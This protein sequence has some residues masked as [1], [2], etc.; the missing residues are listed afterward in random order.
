MNDPSTRLQFAKSLQAVQDHDDT[1]KKYT[2]AVPQVVP[3]AIPQATTTNTSKHTTMKHTHEDSPPPYKY[4]T[5]QLLF[6]TTYYENNTHEYN[7]EF[8]L[9]NI[10]RKK[11]PSH[12]NYLYRRWNNPTARKPKKKTRT[13]HQHLPAHDTAKDNPSVTPTLETLSTLDTRSTHPTNTDPDTILS[14]TIW[15][16]PISQYRI[17][18]RP[19]TRNRTRHPS[20]AVQYALIG[21]Y[22]KLLNLNPSKL[23]CLLSFVTSIIYAALSCSILLAEPFSMVKIDDRYPDEWND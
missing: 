2:K 20:T 9:Y 10:T 22:D 12:D 19:N 23:P 13:T 5:L 17:P 18:F 15:N 1:M 4:D 3:Q 6:L 16:Q 7:D 11:H 8:P 14:I 21:V